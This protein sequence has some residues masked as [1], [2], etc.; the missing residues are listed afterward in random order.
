MT[1][2]DTSVWSMFLRRDHSTGAHVEKLKSII[3]N[4]E[5]VYATGFILQEL[6]QGFHGPKSKDKLIEFFSAV[7]L[8]VPNRQ[9]H[10]D[11]SELRNNAR[12]MGIQIGTIDAL[13]AQL[14]I[15]HGLTLLTSDDDF[16]HMKKLSP[17]LVWH[18]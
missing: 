13:I 4:G 17:I 6:L 8:V 12:R 1:L 16:V 2:V 18:P 9:D 15:R 5:P 14:S 3:S 7:P 10:I 11:A